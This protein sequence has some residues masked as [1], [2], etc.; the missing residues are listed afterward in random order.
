MTDQFTQQDREFIMKLAKEAERVS[1]ENMKLRV[2]IEPRLKKIEEDL[3]ACNRMYDW[4][5]KQMTNRVDPSNV[6][7]NAIFVQF[8]ATD[9]LDIGKKSHIV[10][11][12]K[13]GL[14]DLLKRWGIA[15]LI[16]KMEDKP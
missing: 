6:P 1:V 7:D 3:A 2:E 16:V 9:P 8:K 14:M 11:G 4:V 15:K 10:V 5:M 13:E 12:I